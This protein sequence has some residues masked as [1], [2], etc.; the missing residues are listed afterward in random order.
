VLLGYVLSLEQLQVAENRT[1][2]DRAGV[3]SKVA[4]SEACAKAV[5]STTSTVF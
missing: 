4:S 5:V 3:E 1:S 2:G